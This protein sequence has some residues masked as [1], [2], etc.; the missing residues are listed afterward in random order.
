M[1]SKELQPRWTESKRCNNW[2]STPRDPN[3]PTFSKKTRFLVITLGATGSGKSS[4]ARELIKY[5][6]KINTTGKNIEWQTKVLDEYVE[7]SPEYETAMNTVIDNLRRKIESNGGDLMQELNKL[8]A[9]KLYNEPWFSF[10]KECTQTYFSVRGATGAVDKFNTTFRR[11]IQEGKNILFEITGRN[12]LT[13]IEAL[14]AL[15][16]FTND[17]EKYNYVVLAGY[18][19]VDLYSLQNRNIGRFIS[20]FKNYVNGVPGSH[21]PRLPWVGCFFPTNPGLAFCKALS[22]IK[23]NILKIIQNCGYFHTGRSDGSFG[24]FDVGRKCLYDKVDSFDDAKRPDHHGNGMAVD[25]LFVFNNIYRD[26]KLIAKVPLSDRSQ[27]LVNFNLTPR[28]YPNKQ[29]VEKLLKIVNSYGP[30]ENS[31][32]ERFID[33]CGEGLPVLSKFDDKKPNVVQ[34]DFRSSSRKSPDIM[35]GAKDM[36]MVSS[37]SPPARNIDKPMVVSNTRRRLGRNNVGRVVGGKRRTR[38]R[39]KN[40]RRKTRRRHKKKKSRK[41]KRRRR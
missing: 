40:K 26:I 1:E 27:H 13:T 16:T 19:I 6:R 2:V 3:N 39:R 15:T 31:D 23:Q 12:I 33:V 25:V 24:R 14:N 29:E 36:P 32:P 4:M 30:K 8:D 20:A 10:A 34:Q 28:V 41:S 38:K 17:C 22:D 35:D 9:C 18:N 5:A 21:P 37:S 11:S 7:E